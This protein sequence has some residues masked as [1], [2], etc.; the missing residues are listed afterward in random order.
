MKAE[1]VLAEDM[2]VCGPEFFVACRT[3]FT[4]FTVA[5]IAHA[6][7]I[8]GKRVKPNVNYV[9]VIEFDGHT[10]FEG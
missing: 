8:I 3:F 4:V 9:L 10:P 5:R 6:R 1:N 7:Y 2:H